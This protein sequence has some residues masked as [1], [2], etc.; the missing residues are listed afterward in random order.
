MKLVRDLER[1]L[2]QL[3]DGLAGRVFPGRLHPTELLSRLLRELDFSSLQEAGA[4]VAANIY[5][6][7]FHPSDL[8]DASYPQEILDELAEGVATGAAERGWN[9]RGDVSVFVVS[10]SG[11]RPGQLEIDSEI[12]EGTLAPWARLRSKH[13]VDISKN[14]SIVGRSLDADVV[15]DHETVSRVHATLWREAGRAWVK[16][17][18][19][20]NGTTCD[21]VRLRGQPAPVEIG[22]VITFGAASYV[23]ELV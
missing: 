14:R 15:L 4:T 21:G 16:D 18:G 19:S 6:L 9:L 12:R 17:L 7:R 10:D 2:E 23:F 8:D 22:S 13:P 20:A 3:V 1:R 11:V 5:R